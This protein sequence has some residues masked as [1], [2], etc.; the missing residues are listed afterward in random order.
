MRLDM[1]STNLSQIDKLI[2]SLTRFLAH[3]LQTNASLVDVHVE[4]KALWS[5]LCDLFSAGN[6][7]NAQLGAVNV[8][9]AMIESDFGFSQS[10]DIKSVRC[11]KDLILTLRVLN[12]DGQ[13][14]ANRF[15]PENIKT[16]VDLRLARRSRFGKT[17]MLEITDLGKELL[18]FVD[19][20][21][22]FIR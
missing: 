15:H 2:H 3:C 13:T 18:I 6:H 22:R 21:Y 8:L 4:L 9:I 14:L 10:I 1:D 16:L 12:H 17:H 20:Q 5:T 7:I 19:V 11:D